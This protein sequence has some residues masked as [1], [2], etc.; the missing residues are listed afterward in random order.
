VLEPRVVA[1]WILADHLRVRLQL[2]QH[3]YIWEPTTRGV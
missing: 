2:Q 1:E 3:K